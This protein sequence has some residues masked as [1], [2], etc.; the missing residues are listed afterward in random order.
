MTTVPAE[1]WGG[2]FR[3]GCQFLYCLLV[4]GFLF[5]S[6]VLAGEVPIQVYVPPT[7]AAIPLFLAAD[8]MKNLKVTVF[9]SHSQAHALF[10]RGDIPLLVTGLSVGIRFFENGIP[11]QIINSY[12][13]GMTCLVTRGRKV[14]NFRE[15]VGEEILLPFAGSPIEEI[16]RFFISREGL[17]WQR[18]FKIVYSPPASSLAL[19]K[20]GRVQAVVLPQPLV[21]V[22]AADDPV[23][24]SIDY[25]TR[26]NQLTK[27]R[28]GYPQVGTL[29]KRE[30]ARQH[31]E[32]MARLN[33]EIARAV[34]A[35]KRDSGLAFS[36][37]VSGFGLPEKILSASL[38]GTAFD[39]RKSR[40]LKQDVEHYYQMVGKPL[41]GTYQAFFYFDPQ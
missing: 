30:W 39:F 38:A 18:D 22:A 40:E 34:L 21:A 24:I 7:P 32:V 31:P 4:P 9:A 23:F 41:N 25:R 20:Q 36:R 8:R 17:D 5:F 13:S 28:D 19:L 11:V 1:K 27:S 14:N 26:W 15:L 35:L 6:L 16:T 10:L 33:I 29:V 37:V 3:Q 2:R 12:V